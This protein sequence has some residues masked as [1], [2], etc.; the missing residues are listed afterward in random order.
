MAA[1]A[2]MSDEPDYVARE[3]AFG[4]NRET[5]QFQFRLELLKFALV[6]YII[7]LLKFRSSQNQIGKVCKSFFAS[8]GHLDGQFSWLTCVPNL[9]ENVEKNLKP[10]IGKL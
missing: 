6:L 3:E 2:K 9:K 1:V 8:P 5:M 4:K 7:I 10:Q